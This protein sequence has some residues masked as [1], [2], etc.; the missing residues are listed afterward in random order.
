[1]LVTGCGGLKGCE[2]SS[3]PH[4]LDN[5]KTDGEVVRLTRRPRYMP[6]PNPEGC[7][8]SFLLE[9]ELSQIQRHSATARYS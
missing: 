9:A 7:W 8:C 2:T 4:F 1:M 6:P 3:F 5:Q